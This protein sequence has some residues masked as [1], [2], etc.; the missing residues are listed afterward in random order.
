VAPLEVIAHT[1]PVRHDRAAPNCWKAAQ[2]ET[3]IEE[4]SEQDDEIAPDGVLVLARHRLDLFD[5]IGHL[6]LRRP[7]LVEQR[8][9]LLEPET[10]IALVE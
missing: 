1:L 9:L 2:A 3:G 4:M 7:S 5:H 8:R 10:K 6:E